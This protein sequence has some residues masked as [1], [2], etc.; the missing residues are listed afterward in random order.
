MGSS[1]SSNKS[2]Y[3]DKTTA[4]VPVISH[5]ADIQVANGVSLLNTENSASRC[6]FNRLLIIAY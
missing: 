5:Q 2:T 3:P 6:K 4:V 1:S